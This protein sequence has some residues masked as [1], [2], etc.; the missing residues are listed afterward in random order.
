M[1]EVSG[2]RKAFGGRE[3]LGGVDLTVERGSVVS[4]L[5]PNGA[6]KSTTVR[7]LTTLLAPDAGSVRVGGF[8]V[9]RQAR[10]VR[11]IIGVTGQQTGVD[12]LLTGYENLVMMGRLF[13]LGAAAARRR[14]SELLE[15]FDLA[16]AAGRPVKTYSGGMERRLDL[17]ISMI[18]APPVL[19]LDEPTTGLDPRSRAGVWETVRDLLAGGVT[20][21]L[22]TQYLEEADE[23]ADRVAVI[24][25][26]RVVAEGTP[27]SLKQRVGS[28]RLDLTFA[29]A[30]AFEVARLVLGE[31]HAG[32]GLVL[33]V[34]VDGARDVREVL[35]RL[36]QAGAEVAD[37]ALTRPSLDDVFLSLTGST[38]IG[39]A[40]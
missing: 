35:E 8:D 26:G 18:T 29:T 15:K 2:L 20:V 30:E 7:I 3:V 17:A 11:R 24:D 27:A 39:A 40:R 10:D 1:I 13:R 34:P 31:A 5:G 22:T 25:G 38:T 6:G 12:R 37:L 14:A 9:V 28:E 33:N 32:E 19:F 16:E 21:L 4:L 36:D 23:L